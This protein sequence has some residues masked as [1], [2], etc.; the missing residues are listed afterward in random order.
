[1]HSH[2]SAFYRRAFS[3]MAGVLLVASPVLA[4]GGIP[5]QQLGA[6]ATEAAGAGGALSVTAVQDGARLH[7][8]FQ[9]LDAESGNDGLW[10]VSTGDG[11]EGARFRVVAADAGRGA[12]AALPRTGEVSVAEGKVRF[13]REGLV[14][15]YSV[16]A[17]GVR[18]DFVLPRAPAGSG[19]L[20]LRLSVSGASVRDA[21]GGVLLTPDGTSRELAYSRL[22]VTDATGRELAASMG[23][24][25]E[26]AISIRVEDAGAVYPVRIDPTFSDADWVAMNPQIPGV[27]GAISDMAA[28]A[29]GNVYVGGTFT[30]AGG[31]AASNIARWNG[32]AW[33][34]MGT[35]L[36]DT[37]ALLAV[38]GTTLYA[39][40]SFTTAGG[41]SVARIAK[42]NGSAW[43][44]VGPGLAAGAS[45]LAMT[46]S[47]SNLY[48]GGNGTLVTGA[49]QR[50]SQWNGSTWSAVGGGLNAGVVWAIAVSGPVVWVG[51]AAMVTAGGINLGAVG[52][53]NGSTWPSMGSGMAHTAGGPTV[54]ALAIDGGSVIAGGYFLTAGGVAAQNI[55]R[56]NGVAWTAMGALD[57]VYQLTALEGAFGRRDVYARAGGNVVSRWNGSRWLAHGNNTGPVTMTAS[58]THLFISNWRSST[59]TRLSSWNAGGW[60]L[61]GAED[62]L[63]GAVYAS[64]ASGGSLYGG[65]DFDG[66]QQWNGSMWSDVGAGFNEGV[67]ALL[68]NDGKIYAGGAFTTAGSG[69][70]N[71][72]ASWN[73]TAWAALGAGM[74]GRV[75]ALAAVGGLIYAAGEFTTAGGASANRV[76]RWNGTAWSPLGTGLNGNALALAVIGTD[77]YAGGQ[78]TTAG[79]V[80]ASRIAKWNG[81]AWSA[82]DGGMNGEVAALAARGTTL[83]AGGLFS[84]AGSL[85]AGNVARL[86]A[87][88]WSPLGTGTTGRVNALAVDAANLYAGGAFSDAGGIGAP[89]VAKWNG[90]SW[91]DLSRSEALLDDWVY[92]LTVAD[93]FLYAGG[94]FRNS[95]G[96]GADIVGRWEIQD[97]WAPAA[98]VAA[99]Y[100]DGPVRVISARGSDLYIGG[101]FTSIGGIHMG[102]LAKWNGAAWVNIWGTGSGGRVHTLLWDGAVLYAGGTFG[103][104][105][106]VSA[107]NIV[108]WDGTAWSALGLG[109]S[110]GGANGGVKALL[111]SGPD[112]YAGGSFSES[113]APGYYS[114]ARWNGTAWSPLGTGLP[115]GARTVNTL[116]SYGGAIYAGGSFLSVGGGSGT[117]FAKW[118]GTAWTSP[119]NGMDN[120]IY[121]FA[122]KD[123]FLYAGGAFANA[124]GV[125]AAR[126]ARW[127]GTA[128]AAVGSGMGTSFNSGGGAIYDLLPVGGDLYAAGDFRTTN[129]LSTPAN[130][131]ARWDGSTWSA[132]ASGT[133][134]PVTALGFDGAGGLLTGGQ[135]SKAGGK[136][137]PWFAKFIIPCP[138]IQ[139][140]YPATV[141]QPDGTGTVAMVAPSGGSRQA[142]LTVRNLGGALLTLNSASLNGTHAAR[143][144]VN[145]STWPASIAS[146]AT[147][148][149][150]VTFSSTG[151][152]TSQ[153]TAAL[154]V[155]SNDTAASPYDVNLS[156]WG[157]STTGDTDGDGMMDWAEYTGSAFGFDWQVPNPALIAALPEFNAAAG[158]YSIADMQTLHVPEF[159]HPGPR[160]RAVPPH[161]RA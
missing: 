58:T 114:V 108:R 38:S 18:Q 46:A 99:T 24:E 9:K 13:T 83:F 86:E 6:R 141:I 147:G 133:D 89:N 125:A 23:A 32:S 135:F 65:G 123:G 84:T 37:V 29:L 7:C 107:R 118:D 10:I 55:A 161:P 122:E 102:P 146:G 139:I 14:E 36:N 72:I 90:A 12:G 41:V 25:G 104:A 136:V 74:N 22:H 75:N 130:G 70:A 128:F 4:D 124:G 1:M 95:G 131:V 113:G 17:D 80:S 40:G 155:I 69:A 92:T 54:R 68:S 35:G 52:R 50:L 51:G 150:A 85:A 117:H 140:E 48:I 137:S 53:W 21:A 127:N 154:H 105:G 97:D 156:A 110:L 56:W 16:S 148:A 121:D 152:I 61:M 151:G 62:D 63:P 26:A 59:D 49:G 60:T 106:S 79:G 126:I 115:G 87:G 64:V 119:S 112:L 33:F 100:I 145:T 157:Y 30:V 76:A 120:E 57:V 111:K 31:V 8:G 103:S 134:G 43:S 143:F 45:V 81:T 15:E 73:G 39:Q 20:R 71:R 91:S 19:A 66:V 94:E 101:E 5:F 28:D 98:T 44:A 158:L 93:G 153:N 109:L 129:G 82:V 160:H 149:I 42:W 142:A 11:A 159:R 47:G 67:A 77:L 132:F 3:F 34:P 96:N 144:S 78:F 27:N 88:S 138:I 116:A 2:S